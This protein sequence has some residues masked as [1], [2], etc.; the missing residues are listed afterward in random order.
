MLD[1]KRKDNAKLVEI[2][3][4]DPAEYDT[5]YDKKLDPIECK[6]IGWLEEKNESLVRISWLRETEDAPYVGLSI[7]TGCVKSILEVKS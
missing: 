2:V 4:D 6:A 5:N 1:I 3:F 7:P